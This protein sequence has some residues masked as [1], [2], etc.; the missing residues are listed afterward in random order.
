[1][2]ISASYTDAFSALT[3]SVWRQEGHPACKKHGGWWRCARLSPD[4]VAPSRMVAM[5]ASVNLPLHRKVQK[6]S[7]GIG[8]RG[9][10]Q[11]KGR[12][13]VVC[14]CVCVCVYVCVHR[15]TRRMTCCCSRLL[16]CSAV[17]SSTTAEAP[18]TS[19]PSTDWGRLL[20]LL[21]CPYSINSETFWT[22]AVI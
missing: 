22:L 6:F 1:M 15:E 19:M 20:P 5:S 10:S 12:K 21:F 13:M 14:V 2:I 16:L 9:W 4:G 11:K 7:S 8:S 18:L 17:H 3:L